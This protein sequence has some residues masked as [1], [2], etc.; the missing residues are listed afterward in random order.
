MPA[1]ISF[2]TMARLGGISVAADHLGI[3][4]SGVS[5]HISRLEDHFGVRLVER[6]GRSVKLT[7]TGVRLNQRIQSILADIDVL[8]DIAKEESGEVSGQVNFAATA[9]FGS[10]IAATLLPVAQDR[11]PDLSLVMRPAYDFEDMQDPSTDLAFRI[12]TFEDDRLV[13][14]KLGGFRCWVVASP[15]LA[16]RTVLKEPEDLEDQPCL[17]FRN[18][19]AGSAWTFFASNGVSTVKVGGPFAT[20]SFAVL[21]DLAV[22][23]RGYAFLPEFMLEEALAS[24]RLVR[25]LPQHASRTYSVFL[26]Y[27]PGSRRIA[28]VDALAKLA[29]E[30]MPPLLST[31]KREG[32]C[33]P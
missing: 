21:Y 15:E 4:K 14:K 7:P 25:C 26:T 22:A 29:E 13:A 9:E 8:D 33:R 6:S 24:G 18:D 16:E 12:G 5:R 17:T 11:F 32:S 31:T 10:V 19:V 1:L 30:L 2:H 27:R 20:R 28:R 23:G 3:A